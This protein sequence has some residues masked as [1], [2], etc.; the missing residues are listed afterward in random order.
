MQTKPVAPPP[1]PVAPPS[2]HQTRSN[3]A[4][5][6]HTNIKRFNRKQLNVVSKEIRGET[7]IV[8]KGFCSYQIEDD[9]DKTEYHDEPEEI[10]RKA[11]L[12]AQWMKESN[13]AVA[14]TGA[15]ISTAADIPDYRGPKGVWTL[16]AEGETPASFGERL[17]EASP[18]FAHRALATLM[19]LPSEDE[20]YLKFLVSTNVDG[21]HLMSGVS[22][23]KMS[24][25]H[26][27][28][29]KKECD[30]CKAPHFLISPGS[31]RIR[32][33]VKCQQC[34]CFEFSNTGVGFGSPL[35][36]EEW[37]KAKEHSESCDLALVLGTSLRVSPACNLVEHSY[38]KEG[39]KLVIVNLQ[40][41]PY[42][43]YASMVIRGRTDE[44]M[45]IV[46]KE[47]EVPVYKV[48]EGQLKR[49]LYRE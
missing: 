33:P 27:S 43:K 41:T 12:L 20:S 49:V 40:K 10:E 31:K 7:L 8:S 28:R 22:P 4:S 11:K 15:G 17:N 35:P 18:T 1:P 42:D 26:G 13:Y 30:R 44:V 3:S 23:N 2:N 39:G 32:R 14:Y 36:P 21:L 37:R 16:E 38:K 47:L 46:M 48:V 5:S 34:G 19:Q 25:L 24:E 29:M 6:L 45:R 9:E